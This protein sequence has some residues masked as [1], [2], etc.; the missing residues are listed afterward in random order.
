MLLLQAQVRLAEWGYGN[1]FTAE[2]DSETTAAIRLYQRR[3][4]LPDTGKL[5]GS[6]V[7]RM[8]ADE[9]AVVGYPFTLPPFYFDAEWQSSLFLA[10]G[11][12]RDTATGTTSGP[13]EI[14]CDKERSL[15][16]EQESTT[17][18]PAVAIMNVREWNGDHIIA[19]EVAACYTNQLRIERASRTVTHNSFKTR[20]DGQCKAFEKLVGKPSAGIYSE[21][22]VDGIGAQIERS[23]ARAAAIQRVKLFSGAARSLMDPD[24]D[25]QK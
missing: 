9:K 21:E 20:N 6:T 7:V 5:D 3:N 18:T 1:K 25:K 24:V 13:I 16:L 12:F 2:P 23:K 10:N 15:C 17:L 8:D 19:E 14:R 22:L 4:R 11:V